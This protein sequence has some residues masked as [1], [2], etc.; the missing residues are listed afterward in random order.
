MSSTILVVDDAAF[1]RMMIRDILS[2]EGYIIHEAVNGRDAVDK[3]AEVQPDLVTL[4]ITMPEMNGLDA[5]RAIR[6]V[7]PGRPGPDGQR[8]GPAEDDRRGARGRAR[9]TSWSSR[10]SRRR[11]WR[12]SRSACSRSR[13]SAGA[14]TMLAPIRV[15]V[16]DDSALIRQMLT[17]AL[18]L[19]PRIEVVGIARTGVEAIEK[20]ASCCARRHHARHRDARAHRARSAPVHHQGV[21]TRECSCS[22]SL[23]DPDTTYAALS[24]G[25][26]RLHPEAEGRVRDLARPTS[27]TCSS[28]RSRSRTGSPAAKRM[29]RT[30]PRPPCRTQARGQ[31]DPA[32]SQAAAADRG[33]SCIGRLHRRPAGA[34][35]GVLRAVRATFR[36]RISS[37][38]TSPP[39]SRASFARRLAEIAGFAVVEGRATGMPRAEPGTGYLA[40]HG[41]HMVVRGRARQRRR[42]A[43]DDDLASCTASALRPIRSSRAPPRSSGP[44]SPA[45]VLT[46][47]GQD[48]AAGLAAIRDAGGRHDRP[49]RGDARSCGGCRGPR[50]GSAPRRRSCPSTRSPPRSGGPCA[51]GA[52]RVA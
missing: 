26:R 37:C 34:R 10:S 39:D 35:A 50:C 4:D 32:P 21:A 15:L 7:G 31:R 25:R 2:K 38:S 29:S 5:L 19:D 33:S 40:P 1:M 36:S 13:G 30:V 23:D 42:C 43:L 41:T 51:R 48:G 14:S 18:S 52:D 11:C 16:V 47:M 9:W 17:H 28:R 6:A 22:S 8:H 3:Y 24:R 12:P 20:A 27:P 44:T 45:C 49:G 46:G